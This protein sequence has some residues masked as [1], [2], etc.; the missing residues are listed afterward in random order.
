[1]PYEGGSTG[2][3][4]D[5]LGR[6]ILEG[7]QEALKLTQEQ[8]AK[9]L[10]L[11]SAR[12]IRNWKANLSDL[13]AG[14][15]EALADA[16]ELSEP[17]RVNLYQLTGKLPPAPPAS[18][19]PTAE[20]AV[21]QRMIDGIE[22][23]CVVY[24]YAWDV[25]LTNAPYRALFGVVRRHPTDS[26]LINTTRF[27]LFHP[28]A[29]RILGGDRDAFV[30]SWLMPCVANFT[31]VLGQRPDD[32]RLRSIEKE[33]DARRDVRSA[34]RNAPRWLARTGDMHLNSSPR[35]MFDP[36]SGRLTPVHC[37]TTTHPGWQ[38]Q[39]IQ[40][41]TFVFPPPDDAGRAAAAQLGL[42]PMTG[43]IRAQSLG[44]PAPGP[45]S[46]QPPAP[47]GERAPQAA[48]A[49][50]GAEAAEAAESEEADDQLRRL[51]DGWRKARGFSQTELVKAVGM[52][53][54]R[55]YRYWMVAPT[56][57]SDDLL[58]R[59]ASVL[60]IDEEDSARMYRLAGRLPPAKTASEMRNT[61]AMQLYQK[62]LDG[63]PYPSQVYD[64]S[65][66]V[67]RSNAA[68]RDLF[69]SVPGRGPDSPLRNG[70]RF[71]LFHPDAHEML[72][73][74]DAEAF[75]DAWLMPALA[76]F[77]GVLH[78]SP[79]NPQLL[80]MELEI[81]GRPALREAY[82]LAPRWLR[83]HGDIHVNDMPRPL[84][85]PRTGRLNHVQLVTEAHHGYQRG[86]GLTHVTFVP[87]D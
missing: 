6:Q 87:S 59:F 37:I 31:S 64:A 63:I 67:I 9:K 62:V 78:R 20:L 33:I 72:G 69:G 15:L 32:P 65:W 24:G 4:A 27:I 53:S 28:D 54:D 58:G 26:P 5:A 39:V 44:E 71:V 25:V 48:A 47:R 55:S 51:L 23:P 11:K 3:D 73:G 68:Y 75:H 35:P 29:Y 30:E 76:N 57:L 19:V 8:L 52:Q 66:D 40:V 80:G 56:E 49:V 84:R 21:Y 7:A 77:A 12:T 42:F 74:G 82:R 85:D 18:E 60:G 86:T 61:P 16:L 43:L 22:H 83:E 46:P 79:E 50:E 14:Q 17:N 2:R 13:S 34:Y 70:L 45:A 1:M 10:G 81:T 36:R 38:S 41:A